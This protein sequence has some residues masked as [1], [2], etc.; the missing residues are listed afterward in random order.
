FPPVPSTP[1]HSPSTKNEFNNVQGAAR[2]ASRQ[3]GRKEL[4]FRGDA[5]SSH[6]FH[7]H[8]SAGAVYPNEDRWLFRRVSNRR[9]SCFYCSVR[10]HNCPHRGPQKIATNQ[11]ESFGGYRPRRRDG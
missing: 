8:P 1:S 3:T 10:R 5:A 4:M 6:S 11:A 2:R 9:F 7:S